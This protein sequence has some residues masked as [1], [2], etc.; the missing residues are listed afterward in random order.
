MQQAGGSGGVTPLQSRGRGTGSSAKTTWGLNKA[1]A[2]T[3]KLM[4]KNNPIKK[5]ER[6]IES[7]LKNKPRISL[8][9]TNL[10]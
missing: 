10:H 7:S 2:I 6:I 4:P 1:P 8:I 5:C 9:F 3:N